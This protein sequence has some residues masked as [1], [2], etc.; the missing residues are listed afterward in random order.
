MGKNFRETLNK[1]LEDP[2]FK[3][4]WNDLA[5][6]RQSICANDTQ[7]YR[8]E[9][10]DYSVASFCS[11]GKYYFGT[12]GEI[13]AFINAL[14]K[15]YEGS[16]RELVSAFRAYEGGQTDVTHHVAFQEVPLLT[17][18]KLVHAEKAV[19]KN[20]AWDH[21]N[22][23]RRAYKIPAEGHRSGGD[24]SGSA[25]TWAALRKD[26]SIGCCSFDFD[27]GTAGS[28]WDGSELPKAADKGRRVSSFF[29]RPG[30]VMATEEYWNFSDFRQKENDLRS[31]NGGGN[32]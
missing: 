27:H 24:W 6:E 4:E 32:S 11:F 31:S 17:P 12:L 8:L 18:A 26:R 2:K 7:Y 20:H 3:A 28:N 15:E 13:R 30:C 9:L 22:I 16:H 14:D 23:W 5:I 10:D 1:Q 21:I 19:L 25:V 29:Q